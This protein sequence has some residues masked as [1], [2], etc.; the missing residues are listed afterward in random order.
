M[1]DPT[2]IART[3]A[4]A[5]LD[6]EKAATY[7]AVMAVFRN[8]KSRFLLYLR[9]AEIHAALRD[10]DHTL[11]DAELVSVL[12][13]LAAWGNV[14]C[15]TDTSDVATVEEFLRPRFLYQL[16]KQGEA[17]AAAVE[18]FERLL[19]QHAELKAAAL[20]DIRRELAALAL[21]CCDPDPD[22]AKVN[23]A[24][25]E[26]CTRFEELTS[27]A[28]AFIASLQRT[29]DLQGAD[30][31]A[32]V[33]YKERL[34][35][36]LERFIGELTYSTS[37]IAQT[38]AVIERSGVERL[39]GIASE[40]DLADA[41][42]VTAADRS[43]AVEA[44]RSRWN[45][46]RAW[47]VTSDQHPSQAEVLRRRA[48][49]AIPALLSAL[50]AINDRS[51]MRSDRTSDLRTL[52]RWFAQAPSEADAHR[53]WRA[54]FCLSPSRHLSI[55]PESLDAYDQAPVSPHTSW[56]DAP[57]LQLS[58]RLRSGGRFVRRGPPAPA[59][60]RTEEKKLLA[61]VAAEEARQIA[62]AR[63]RLTST[64]A[65]RLSELGVL[66]PPEFHLFLDL[67]GEALA[68]ITNRDQAVEVLSSDGTVRVSLG[69]PTGSNPATI[70]TTE[71]ALVGPDYTIAIA[72]TST[73]PC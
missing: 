29:I 41:V 38:L 25:R 49:E 1:L 52:A 28:Q 58:P 34:I 8:A 44:W 70:R 12:E 26:I 46:L 16:T 59:V 57:P 23:T 60:D 9:P 17:A 55:D 68:A 47:F 11:T 63:R 50:A 62:Q 72:G 24:L 64:G 42:T 33:A 31:K 3:R 30:L 19:D 35:G 18:H 20:A 15:H 39:L 4:F 71:G 6:S 2:G 32:F 61:A 67:L 65:T 69:P 66:D 43:A 27:H 53:L 36:Y 37:D 73:S 54:A 48:R 51:V 5:Y 22:R 14:D 45:G 10:H 56:Y 13:S 40:R 21:V 7:R